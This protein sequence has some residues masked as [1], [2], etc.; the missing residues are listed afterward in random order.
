MN[1]SSLIPD[2]E[3]LILNPGSLNPESSIQL[4]QPEIIVTHSEAETS[5]AGERLAGR[6]RPGDVLLLDGDLGAGKT[7]FVRGLA[8][9]LDASPDEVTSPT[10]TLMQTYRGR[11]TLVHVDLYRLSPEE[12]AGLGIEESTDDPAV[13]AV[14]WAERWRNAPLGA[15]TIRVEDQGGDRRRIK[16]SAPDSRIQ[17]FKDSGSGDSGSVISDE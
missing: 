3:S 11:L 7:A 12:V 8:Q 14:E 6:L 13:V 5:A 9:G 2:P 10:F 16:I 17:G 1:H 4:T 15:W